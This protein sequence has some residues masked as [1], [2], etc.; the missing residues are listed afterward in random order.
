[1]ITGEVK[2]A[3]KAEAQLNW[4]GVIE[5]QLIMLMYTRYTSLIVAGALGC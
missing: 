4:C 3:G 1:M 5:Y 2:C